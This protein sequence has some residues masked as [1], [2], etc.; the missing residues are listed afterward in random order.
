[1]IGG[2][3]YF[4]F[5]HPGELAKR[6][7]NSQRS[8][9]DEN[10][11]SFEFAHNE[12]I[13]AQ[14][15]RSAEMIVGLSLVLYIHRIEAEVEEAR[16]KER[17][18]FIQEIQAMKQQ[19]QTELEQEKLANNEKL[20]LLENELVKKTNSMLRNHMLLWIP[21]SQEHH[22]A[23]LKESTEN[24][25]VATIKIAELEEKNKVSP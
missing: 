23:Q 20:S 8:S 6:G 19:A 25:I 13:Q 21:L 10:R 16:L 5:N 24:S 3:H 2:D 18:I 14:T 12:F 15:A 7:S 4:R 11:K 1:M 17:E 9:L 22:E